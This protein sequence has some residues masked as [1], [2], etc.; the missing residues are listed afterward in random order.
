MGVSLADLDLTDLD[1]RTAEGALA[2]LPALDAAMAYC[3]PRI[4]A[5]AYDLRTEVHTPI[6][7]GD[8]PGLGAIWDDL[9]IDLVLQK[10]TQIGAS[11]YAMIRALHSTGVRGRTVIYTMPDDDAARD[12][13]AARLDKIIDAAAILRMLLGRAGVSARR[14]PTDNTELKQIGPGTLYIRGTQGQSGALSVPAQEL[15]EDEIDFSN[16]ERLE[17]YE[18]RLDALP[19][20][21]RRKLRL[22]TPTADGVGIAAL[23]ADSDARVWMVHCGCGWWG[24]LD[25]WTHTDGRHLELRCTECRRVLDPR[26]GEWVAAHPD[27]DRHGYKIPRLIAA[28]PGAPA[29]SL[30]ADLHKER[31]DKLYLA[32]FYN[33]SLGETYNEGVGQLTEQQLEGACF[34]ED[35]TMALA[36][37]AGTGPYY[38]GIDQGDTL[39]VAILRADPRMEPGKLR[40]VY[41]V[42]LRDPSRGSAAWVEAARL[43]T[44]FQVRLCVVDGN[45]NSAPAHDLARQFP[46]RVL[47]CYYQDDARTE[48]AEAADVR[49]RAE[50]G[51]RGPMERTERVDITV[52]RTDTLD[53]LVT[54]LLGGAFLFFGP[55]QQPIIREVITHCVN[56]VRTPVYAKRGGN[57]IYRWVRRG[58]NDFFHALN[59][60]RIASIEGPRLA[61]LGGGGGAPMVILGSKRR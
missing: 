36:A 44:V 28:F 43:L 17:M 41:A 26:V 35:F 11:L 6:T 54:D 5:H 56:N 57:P 30:L 23:Y 51:T 58:V 46:G 31:T 16:P 48:I 38:A 59:Y 49:K 61:R 33:M 27:K 45:P 12:L 10:P 7:F 42:R 1:F 32:H 15:I 24:P 55:R 2:S 21:Q 29:A 60:G 22:S 52:D 40:L 25:Y 39:T 13:V 47:V 37:M 20:E 3:L 4:W 53:G 50:A 34:L 19:P 9:A 18:H 14:R 8:R